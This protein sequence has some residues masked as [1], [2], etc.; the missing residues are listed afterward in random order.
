MRPTITTRLWT[1]VTSDTEL[2]EHFLA[3]YFCW[4]YPIFASLSKEHEESR[5]AMAYSTQAQ[6]KG[7][8]EQK[9]TGK[10]IGKLPT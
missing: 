6:K 7:G 3:L 2:I 4:E 5:I 10:M 8:G 1:T 9:I